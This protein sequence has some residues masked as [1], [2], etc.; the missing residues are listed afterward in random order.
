MSRMLKTFFRAQQN[1][2]ALSNHSTWT[3]HSL[4][5]RAYVT[6]CTSPVFVPGA[7]GLAQS[8]HRSGTKRDVVVLIPSSFSNRDKYAVS[9]QL[10]LQIVR[11]RKE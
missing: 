5:G 10:Q 2:I 9:A 11:S 4:A 8:I 1:G 3:F 6:T 7:I